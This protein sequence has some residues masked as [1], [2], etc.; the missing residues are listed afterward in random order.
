M[1]KNTLT[2]GKL[3][4]FLEDNSDLSDDV[5]LYYP[6]Y[7]KGYGLYPVGEIE[8]GEIPSEHGDGKKETVVVLD[9]CTTLHQDDCWIEDIREVEKK[10]ESK[11]ELS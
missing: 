6:Y 4:K 1:N 11:N 8:T 2:I 5:I 3:K 7:Y 10:L 9:W